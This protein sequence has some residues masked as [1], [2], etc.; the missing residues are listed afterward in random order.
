MARLKKRK[1]LGAKKGRIIGA[2]KQQ[3][4]RIKR[5]KTTNK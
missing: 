3:E 2:K 1:L 4:A 5:I